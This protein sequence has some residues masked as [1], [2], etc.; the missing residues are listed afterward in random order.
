MIGRER[1]GESDRQR[2]LQLR[3]DY[4]MCCCIFDA[5][6][7]NPKQDAA[8]GKGGRVRGQFE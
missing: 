2:E 3:A 5:V 1:E 6:N 4:R 8:C 7:Q